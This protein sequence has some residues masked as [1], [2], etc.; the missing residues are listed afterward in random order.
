MREQSYSDFWDNEG[1]DLFDGIMGWLD[2]A[3]EGIDVTDFTGKDLEEFAHEAVQDIFESRQ[4]DY[5]DYLYDPMRD[6]AM[7]DD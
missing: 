3:P 2:D 7:M 5:V 6:D 4:G 1:C